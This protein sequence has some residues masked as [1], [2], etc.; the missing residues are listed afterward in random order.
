MPHTPIPHILGQNSRGMN[1]DS[2]KMPSEIGSH[3]S[4]DA[5]T[6]HEALDSELA[7]SRCKYVD[8]VGGGV[9]VLC[10]K[11]AGALSPALDG[12]VTCSVYLIPILSR[13]FT[14]TIHTLSYNRGKVRGV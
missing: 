1:A 9:A 10:S 5:R 6:Q 14:G 12:L 4:L 8:R 13:N 3:Q 11:I 2:G 7:P